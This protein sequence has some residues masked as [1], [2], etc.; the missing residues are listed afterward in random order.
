MHRKCLPALALLAALAAGPVA[1]ETL[2]FTAIPDQDE[3][4]LRERFDKVS[5]YLESQL[6]VDVRYVPVKSYAAAVTAFRNNQV[7]L[8]WFGGLSG[9]RAREAGATFHQAELQAGS[10]PPLPEPS[11][12]NRRPRANPGRKKVR[13]GYAP[14]TLA[15]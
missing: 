12:T 10:A 2:V 5:D 7:Q 14:L 9:V 8:A 1:A 13:R 15:R 3:T 4:A 11:P 6:A